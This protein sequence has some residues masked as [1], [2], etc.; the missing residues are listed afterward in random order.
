[1]VYACLK[2]YHDHHGKHPQD[3]TWLPPIK[4][5]IDLENFIKSGKRVDV[6]GLSNYM[7]NSKLNTHLTEEIKKRNP[8]C[9]VICGGPEFDTTNKKNFGKLIDLYVPIEGE[10]T[11]SNLL[12]A[13]VEQKSWKE[14]GGIVFKDNDKIVKT[15]PLPWIRDW[16]H[17][18]LL[19]NS[20]YMK[21]VIEENASLGLKT[22]LQ[23]E[24]TRGCP[25]SCTYCDWGGGIHTKIRQRSLDMLKEEITWT[26]QNKIWK[27]FITDANFGILQRD[28]DVAQHIVDTK[29]EY[30][31]PKGVI[32]QTAKN[33]T[34]RIV[35]VADILF[36]GGV[37]SGHMMSVQSTDP[38][39]LANI[40][41]SNLP[42][43]KQKII[44]EKLHDR[45]VP[46]K[47]Q[48]IVGLPGDNL[49]ILKDSVVYLYNMGVRSEV[50]NFI[51]GLFPN[52]PAS[53]KSYREEMKLKTHYGYSGILCRDITTGQGYGG[54]DLSVCNGT[55][56]TDQSVYGDSLWAEVEDKSELVISTYSYTE[57]EWA[58]MFTWLSTFN[59]LV[60]L[61]LFKFISDFYNQHDISYE[62][63]IHKIVELLVDNDPE[64]KKLYESMYTQTLKFSMKEKDYG[65]VQIPGYE[66]NVAF[67]MSFVIQSWIAGHKTHI[68]EKWA[69]IV[70]EEFGYYEPIESLFEF[71]TDYFLGYDAVNEYTKTYDY[72]W[73]TAT[74]K[75][76]Y[77]NLV[78]TNCKLHFKNK[79]IENFQ[80]LNVDMDPYY[81]A[82]C[83][84]YGR[85]RKM[86]NYNVNYC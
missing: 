64:F 15:P 28:V 7:W 69:I 65:E 34:E 53:Q 46:V 58:R 79:Y 6:L 63:F 23:F 30:G 67:D 57:E 85:N 9:F 83:L 2:S 22:L 59:G 82:L 77:N 70:Q 81:Y 60:E 56:V 33:Q 8:N 49:P 25:Y 66:N 54:Y 38:T 31:Y 86:M 75:K 50:E 12:D 14:V 5:S 27:Y 51:F 3:I 32:Y 61:G 52:A 73:L 35:D 41:R 62:N 84:V 24:T 16:N 45:G 72:D 13:L 4:N 48:I 68:K 80:R 18:P 1:M 71:C 74:K 76:Q 47:S 21:Q 19:E 55:D 26:G 29:K 17:S 36:K 42:P 44:A 11:F 20:D 78:K 37:S 43:E 39:V 10:A 40:K